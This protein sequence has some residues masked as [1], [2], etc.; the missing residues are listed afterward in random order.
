MKMGD[1]TDRTCVLPWLRRCGR[2]G[3]GMPADS[4]CLIPEPPR[5]QHLLSCLFIS[6]A[7]YHLIPL[8][9]CCTSLVLATPL[10]ILPL[11]STPLSHCVPV[12]FFFS[13]SLYSLSFSQTTARLYYGDPPTPVYIYTCNRPLPN[14]VFLCFLLPTCHF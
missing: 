8:A 14:I 6:P 2:G 1:R 12:T 4:A 7:A 3:V 5:V 11:P 9:G 10:P 13:F